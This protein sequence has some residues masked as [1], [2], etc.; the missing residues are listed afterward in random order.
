M[1]RI[2]QSSADLPGVD[3]LADPDQIFSTFKTAAVSA[4]V[5]RQAAAS[6]ARSIPYVGMISFSLG[7]QPLSVSSPAKHFSS[8][9]GPELQYAAPLRVGLDDLNPLTCD[10]F[11]PVYAVSPFFS[12][13]PP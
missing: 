12:I 10:R 4:R 6:L 5:L 11:A 13:L 3:N 1:R 7:S 9:F 2:T 8:Q